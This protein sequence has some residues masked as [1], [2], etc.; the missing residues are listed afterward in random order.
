MKKEL[1]LGRQTGYPEFYDPGLLVG[2]ARD[3]DTRLLKEPSFHGADVWNAWEMTW[4]DDNGKPDVATVRLVVPAA[5]PAIVESKSLK[6]YLNSFSQHAVA[7]RARLAEALRQDISTCVGTDVAIRI[8]DVD[9]DPG[10]NARFGDLPGTCIDALPVAI[11]TYS[12]EPASLRADDD[13]EV[14]ESLHSHL[15]R[16]LCP[17]TSQPDSGSL[18]VSYRGPRIDREGLLRYIVSFRRHNDFHEACAERVFAD[19]REFCRP[20]ELTVCAYYLRRGG[21]DINPWRSTA[22]EPPVAVRLWRQ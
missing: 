4:L 10:G 8:D 1:P 11:N 15:L 12:V 14:T 17:V 3:R 6:L 13:D 18:L 7:S 22:S 2:I 16:S 9:G 21:I 20:T 5:S 19:I